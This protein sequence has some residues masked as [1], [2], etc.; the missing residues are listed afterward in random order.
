[1]IIDWE[2]SSLFD[3]VECFSSL[4]F[5]LVVN[6]FKLNHFVVLINGSSASASEIFASALKDHGLATI[7]GQTTYG[8]G[9]VQSIIPTFDGSYL[10]LTTSEYYTPNGNEINKIGVKP[11]V[12]I[13]DDESTK[14]DEQLIKAI[15]ILKR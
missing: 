4:S 6:S 14:E 10:K 2:I 13:E 5:L 8:K 7:V 1:M 9:L 12:E 3:I 11:D 15:E